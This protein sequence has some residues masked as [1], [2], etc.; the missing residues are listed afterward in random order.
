MLA[1]IKSGIFELKDGENVV[2]PVVFD[3]DLIKTL[4]KTDP[5]LITQDITEIICKFYMNIFRYL[6][7]HGYVNRSDLSLSHDLMEKQLM[8]PISICDSLLK[9]NKNEP[10]LKRTIRGDKHGLFTKVRSEI[11]P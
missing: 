3:D 2:R 5:A 11:H 4:I 7:T 1:K 9:L 6:K 10:F 8:K